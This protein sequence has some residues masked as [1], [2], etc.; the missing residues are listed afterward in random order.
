MSLTGHSI[1][2]VTTHPAAASLDAP[3]RI[4]ADSAGLADA[5]ED[6]LGASVEYCPGWSVAD[7]VW[8]VLEVQS[9]W[10]QIVARGLDD[11]KDAVRIERPA[12]SALIERFRDGAGRLVAALRAAHPSAP[13]WTWS[14][15]HDAGF[16]IR[17]QVQEAAIHRWDAE[18][19]AGREFAVDPA[20]AVDAIEEFLTFST[21]VTGAEPLGGAIAFEATD[22]DASWAVGDGPGG[23]VRWRRGSA[24]EPDA[25]LRGTAS[26]LLLWLYGRIAAERVAIGDPAVLGRFRSHVDTS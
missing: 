13:C 22:A 6:N 19:A 21:A 25:R 23:T 20:A 5:A 7:L 18:H 10:G 17:H 4:A 8:H 12:D 2:P 26:D 15:Q 11:P 24:G 16:V 1:W 3:S 14:T 9:F